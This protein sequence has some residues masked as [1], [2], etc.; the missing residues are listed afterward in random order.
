MDIGAPKRIIEI[1][2]AVP[3]VPEPMRESPEPAVEPAP[4]PAEPGR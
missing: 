3:P 2:P 1:E 4:V